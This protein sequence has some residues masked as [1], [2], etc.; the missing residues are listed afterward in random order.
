[1]ALDVKMGEEIMETPPRSQRFKASLAS[2]ERT[3]FRSSQ[4]R[5]SRCGTSSCSPPQHGPKRRRMEEV[6][7]SIGDMPPFARSFLNKDPHEDDGPILWAAVGIPSRNARFASARRDPMSSEDLTWVAGW[8]R[9]QKVAVQCHPYNFPTTRADFLVGDTVEPSVYKAHKRIGVVVDVQREHQMFRVKWR[10]EDGGWDREW[11]SRRALNPYRDRSNFYFAGQKLERDHD[12]GN[13]IKRCTRCCAAIPVGKPRYTVPVNRAVR[14]WLEDEP[15][16]PPEWLDRSKIRVCDACDRSEDYWKVDEADACWNWK[17]AVPPMGAGSDHRPLTLPPFGIYVVPFPHAAPNNIVS[18]S[19]VNAHGEYGYAEYDLT[20]EVDTETL[21]DTDTLVTKMV[22]L[23][24]KSSEI[25]GEI[26]VHTFSGKPGERGWSRTH[27]VKCD[28]CGQSGF[29]DPAQ[30]GVEW[31][32]KAAAAEGMVV[33]LRKKRSDSENRAK[34][35]SCWVPAKVVQV[36]GRET[37]YQLL[38]SFKTRQ[39]L[40]R[41]E[42][43]KVWIR[44]NDDRFE[45]SPLSSVKKEDAQD[46][47]CCECWGYGNKRILSAIN[48]NPRPRPLR[49]Y[50]VIT[51]V[52]VGGRATFISGFLKDGRVYIP[53]GEDVKKDERAKEETCSMLPLVLSHSNISFDAPCWPLVNDV[54]VDEVNDEE[55]EEDGMMIEDLWGVGGI[56]T[57]KSH[58]EIRFCKDTQFEDIRI[59][60]SMLSEGKEDEKKASFTSCT[61]F[62]SVEVR[63]G[64]KTRRFELLVGRTR[65]VASWVQEGLAVNSYYAC[66]L[67][68]GKDDDPVWFDPTYSRNEKVLGNRRVVPRMCSCP[69]RYVDTDF[70]GAGHNSGKTVVGDGEGEDLLSELFPEA[71]PQVWRR[72]VHG[73][74]PEEL[75]SRSRRRWGNRILSTALREVLRVVNVQDLA[76]GNEGKKKVKIGEGMWQLQANRER[77]RACTL[78]TE[79]GYRD[80]RTPWSCTDA[81]RKCSICNTTGG[82]VACQKCLEEQRPEESIQCAHVFCARMGMM[83]QSVSSAHSA[84]G[85]VR[86]QVSDREFLCPEHSGILGGRG[87]TMPLLE[88]TCSEQVGA[89]AEW[90]HQSKVTIAGV[91]KGL[92]CRLQLVHGSDEEPSVSVCPVSWPQFWDAGGLYEKLKDVERTPS[93]MTRVEDCMWTLQFQFLDFLPRRGADLRDE[94]VPQSFIVVLKSGEDRT[95]LALPVVFGGRPPLGAIREEF[96][97]QFDSAVRSVGQLCV[98]VY[99][100]GLGCNRPLLHLLGQDPR[101][102]R[103]FTVH[104][105]ASCSSPSILLENVALALFGTHIWNR[106]KRS[107]HK[108]LRNYARS[109]QR[110]G[111]LHDVLVELLCPDVGTKGKSEMETFL[112]RRNFTSEAHMGDFLKVKRAQWENMT[113]EERMHAYE[114]A[115]EDEA[116]SQASDRYFGFR[117]GQG[118]PPPVD[119]SLRCAELRLSRIHLLFL[120]HTSHQPALVFPPLYAAIHRLR[121]A[122]HRGVCWATWGSAWGG[123]GLHACGLDRDVVQELHRIEVPYNGRFDVPF[124][125]RL[126]TI[127]WGSSEVAEEGSDEDADEEEDDDPDA[128]LRIDTP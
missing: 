2:L 112:A 67:S 122:V 120:I 4:S 58:G 10:R 101:L 110:E 27:F 39:Y 62:G 32:G 24:Q 115:E 11:W 60:I 65:G 44:G 9:G 79:G 96:L 8:V 18:C 28:A 66:R 61:S 22:I 7:A 26:T 21:Q 83:L 23:P 82:V 76:D 36:K 63:E 113:A 127:G 108:G 78:V 114:I 73:H 5:K 117:P 123:L 90:V 80:A 30:A 88:L 13:E 97:A 119:T 42:Y 102:R 3:P 45:V 19:L 98:P 75:I 85:A 104:V 48:C 124:P 43:E 25:L 34:E 69:L 35:G 16:V 93:R 121:M 109:L 59:P 91:R 14:D 46:A 106:K 47:V 105:D 31:D 84:T 92:W 56:R 64:D 70:A 107:W 41:R 55:G 77:H 99:F 116:N 71:S 12:D 118:N 57:R 53:G 52:S 40:R 54:K 72:M 17:V 51:R 1:M 89:E 15:Q 81:T 49:R 50:P 68:S 95:V 125:G 111:E 86:W 126:P 6:G 74:R 33:M 38:G 94:D 87:K 29:V 100:S 128:W 20:R 37:C 103:W